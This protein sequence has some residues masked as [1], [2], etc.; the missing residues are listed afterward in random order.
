M[1]A[2]RRPPRRMSTSRWSRAS[3]PS[4]P[5]HCG[6]PVL[7]AARPASARLTMCSQSRSR[8]SVQRPLVVRAG[9]GR[10]GTPCVSDRVIWSAVTWR[11]SGE[12]WSKARPST[13]RAPP[14]RRTC[15]SS[16]EDRRRTRRRV[17]ALGTGNPPSADRLIAVPARTHREGPLPNPRREDRGRRDGAACVARTTSIAAMPR[18]RSHRWSPVSR[19]ANRPGGSPSARR[20]PHHEER[21][22]CSE[23]A[24]AISRCPAGDAE[25]AGGADRCRR[26][27]A[28]GAAKPAT[29]GSGTRAPPS[30]DRKAVA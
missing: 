2:P 14:R 25:E 19:R 21:D 16:R 30:G 1:R 11:H 18:R 27:R 8:A 6:Q 10:R 26:A 12:V 24:T 17:F 9:R 23:H 4:S 28:D 22:P 29:C 7:W 3:R 13:T 5:S 15:V 20:A